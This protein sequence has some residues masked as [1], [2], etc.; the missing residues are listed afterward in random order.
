[1]GRAGVAAGESGEGR[2]VPLVVVLDADATYPGDRILPTVDL[3][4]GGADLVIGVRHPA[5]GGP[6]GVRDLV[7]RVGNLGL[8]YVA[9]VLARRPIF[10][11]CSGFW[12]VSTERFAELGLSPSSFAIEADL[13]LRSIRR[14]YRV[15]QIPIPYYERVGVAKLRAFRDG[16]QILRTIISQARPRP[17]PPAPRHGDPSVGGAIDGMIE[18]ATGRSGRAHP[19][20][21]GL[22]GTQTVPRT[23]RRS[24]PSSLHV[25]TARLNFEPENQRRHLLSANRSLAPRERAGALTPP[26][27]PMTRMK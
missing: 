8:S 13:V 22:P 19:P 27:A 25:V 17:R 16:G 5:W 11:L 10:D 12:G 1:V 3:L 26:D 14:G 18:L 20:T 4:R 6:A 7:H 21:A 24:R 2:G 9:S 15:H 23:A